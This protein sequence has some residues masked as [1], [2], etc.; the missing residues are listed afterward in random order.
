[1]LPKCNLSV[2]PSVVRRGGCLKKWQQLTTNHCGSSHLFLQAVV[3]P[4]WTKQCDCLPSV[5]LC[6]KTASKA[7]TQ[8]HF[9]SLSESVQHCVVGLQILVL[10]H[11]VAQR[12]I[13]HS[14]LTSVNMD[15]LGMHIG[16]V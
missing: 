5:K 12:S 7:V 8:S 4:P 15:K 10:E 16:T 13:A 3:L 11:A 1:M 9:F 2:C 14:K 6:K